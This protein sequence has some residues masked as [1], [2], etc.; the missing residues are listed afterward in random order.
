MVLETKVLESV[1]IDTKCPIDL[2]N[3]YQYGNQINGEVKYICKMCGVTYSSL[4]PEY[5]RNKTTEYLKFLKQWN[6]S[7][8]E[9]IRERERIIR[10]GEERGFI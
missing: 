7:D 3:L 8:E 1:E 9:R 4:D 6:E 2:V 5:M 10:L